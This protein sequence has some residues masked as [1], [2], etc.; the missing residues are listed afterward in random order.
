LLEQGLV[1]YIAMDVKAGSDQYGA[2]CT[3]G[4]RPASVKESIALIL[5]RSPA[6]EFRTTCV[7]PFVDTHS[8][9]VIAGM[10]AGARVYYL[11]QCR[12]PQTARPIGGVAPQPCSDS[13]MAELQTIASRFV[14]HCKIRS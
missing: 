2:L 8:M 9:P 3:R 1:D 4:A 7:K 6:Y 5:S 11:Q 14:E 12:L 13:E 10:I